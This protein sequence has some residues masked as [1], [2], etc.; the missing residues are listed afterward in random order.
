[1]NTYDFV[2]DGIN[3]FYA[4]HGKRPKSVVLSPPSYREL[5]GDERLRMSMDSY[6]EG[7]L[8][9]YG[10]TIVQQRGAIAH[11]VAEEGWTENL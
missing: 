11:F 9:F 4:K 6:K 10:A 2:V 3:R 5:L 1:M 7:N 8:Q